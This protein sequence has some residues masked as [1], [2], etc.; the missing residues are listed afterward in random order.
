VAIRPSTAALAVEI[1]G[2]DYDTRHR[3]EAIAADRV[4]ELVVADLVTRAIRWFR[5]DR[6]RIRGDRDE[7]H[8]R[9]R[10]A[11]LA[12]EIKRRPLGEQ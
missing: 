1:V 11:S 5:S 6:R 7:P 12:A 4:G 2:R 8:A 9:H 3:P 10:P